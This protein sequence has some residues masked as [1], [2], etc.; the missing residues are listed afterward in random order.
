MRTSRRLLDHAVPDEDVPGQVRGGPQIWEV[1]SGHGPRGGGRRSPVPVRRSRDMMVQRSPRTGARRV[2]AAVLALT[3]VG[4]S[5]CDS[6][7]EPPAPTTP[8]ATPRPFT[9]MSTDQVTVT[10]PAAAT[11]EASSMFALNAFQR[12]MTAPPGASGLALKPDAARDC[13][14]FESPTI[15]TC[16]LQ[17]DLTF[18]GGDPLTSSDVKFSIDRA[19]RLDVPGSSTSL[20]SALR[21]IDTPDDLTVRFVLSRVDGQFGWAL[22]SPAASIVDEER[23]DADE[24]RSTSQLAVGSGPFVVTSFDDDR[25]A[26][27]KFPDYHG[28]SPAAMASLTWVTAA[29][30]ATIEDAMERREVDLVW[31]GLNVAAVTRLSQQV[32]ASPDK[33]TASGFS[34]KVLVGTRVE[35]L[36]WSPASP[37]RGNKALRTAIA[38]A[39]Q[40][41]RTLDSILPNGIAG[42]VSSY[43]QGGKARPK[44]TWKNRINLALAYDQTAPN[45]QDLANTVRNRLE[46]T[47]G[48]SVR[49]APRSA[50]A[51][52]VLVDRKAWTATPL[53]WLQPYVDDPLPASAE[54]VEATT[55]A[56]AASYDDVASARLLATLQRQAAS[57]LVLLPISQ[58]DETVWVR[59][60]AGINAGSYGPGWQLGLFGISA[61]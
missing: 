16:T 21:R 12:L 18:A 32:G 1:V 49:L 59:G 6:P 60:G 28:F 47:G 13:G 20:L 30:S 25:I 55:N 29:D 26:F 24:V 8:G 9:V 27:A 19:L 36:Q 31:R 52:L 54:S 48:L 61:S 44:V 51:D 22:A 57:D 5:A 3:V 23:Y 46:D 7:S 41:D 38:L 2:L 15:Y 10:D 42:H 4:L 56:V 53:A 39:L 50:D 37:A 14:F 58:S 40:G 11:D 34:Q 33:V 43:P 35:M 45:A 17:K